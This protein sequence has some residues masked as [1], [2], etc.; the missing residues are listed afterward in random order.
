LLNPDSLV[1]EKANLSIRSRD[2][3]SHLGFADPDDAVV[4]SLLWLHAAA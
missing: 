4:G 3:L 2:Y 1:S